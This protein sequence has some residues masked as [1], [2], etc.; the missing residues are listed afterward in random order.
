M[1]ARRRHALHQARAQPATSPVTACSAYWPARTGALTHD[2]N[3]P[4][5]RAWVMHAS[6][7]RM[8]AWPRRAGFLAGPARGP[9]YRHLRYDEI[10]CWN[11][12]RSPIIRMTSSCAICTRQCPIEIRDRPVQKRENRHPAIRTSARHKPCDHPRADRQRRC[13]NPGNC[14][15]LCRLRRVRDDL[16]GRT[17][18]DRHRYRQDRR[19]GHHLRQP[20]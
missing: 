11:R 15:R 4:P 9:D 14:R 13:E 7:D 2:L 8:P 17:D 20:R 16:P 3:Y 18:R 1:T 10:D 5:T 12:S 19:Y 6:R